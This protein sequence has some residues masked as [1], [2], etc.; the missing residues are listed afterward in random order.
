MFVLDFLLKSV[1][2]S[3]FILMEHF[4]HIFSSE[5]HHLRHG[6]QIPIKSRQMNR[7]RLVINSKDVQNCMRAVIQGDK[8]E[9][10]LGL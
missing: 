8:M 9:M 7:S 2:A 6:I 1:Y 5:F 4:H 10:F 3:I